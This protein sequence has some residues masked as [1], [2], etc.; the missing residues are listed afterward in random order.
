MF[1]EKLSSEDILKQVEESRKVAEIILESPNHPDWKSIEKSPTFEDPFRIALEAGELALPGFSTLDPDMMISIFKLLADLEHYIFDNTR[2]RPH[3]ILLIAPPGSGKSHFIK[4][5]ASRL[6]VP[7]VVGNLSVPDPIP[8]L[9]FV[10][11]EA[12][13]Y[14]AQDKLPLIFLGSG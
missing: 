1:T 12:R 9:S 6:N 5:L 3:N 10:V 13:N 4:C 11:N 14:K 2:K 8:V 7:S